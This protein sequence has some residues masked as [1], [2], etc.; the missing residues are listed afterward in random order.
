MTIYTKRG[1]RGKT[2]LFSGERVQKTNE[3]IEA[4]GAVDELNSSLGVARSFLE[5]E[6]EDVSEII[7]QLQSHLHMI[8]AN[9]ANTSS[10]EDRPEIT[11]EHLE[12]ME[13]QIDELEESLP[14]LTNFILAGGVPG[15][16]H[17]HEAR[18]ICRRAERRAVQAA[19]NHVISG[20]VIK[21]LNRLSD[22]LFVMARTVNHRNDQSE[23]E[24][25]YSL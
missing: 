25:D 1:D 16:S 18:T 6:C 5:E 2:D 23:K 17:L 8:C 4:Y 12:S 24:P 21:Y 11:E 9:L 20:G 14:P 13:D 22:L 7:L 10:D 19:E 15:G 3:R